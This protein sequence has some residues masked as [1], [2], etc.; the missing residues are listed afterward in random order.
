MS[1]ELS[2]PV[3][4]FFRDPVREL[5]VEVPIHELLEPGNT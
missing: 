2:D 5:D 1:A 3:S 4:R